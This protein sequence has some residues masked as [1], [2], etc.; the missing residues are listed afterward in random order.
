MASF[1]KTFDFNLRK[2]HQKKFYER[3]DYESADEK[4]LS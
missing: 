1:S 3:H 2:D 4:S